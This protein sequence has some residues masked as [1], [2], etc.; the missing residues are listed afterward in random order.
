[1]T[2]EQS[3]VDITLCRIIGLTGGIGM[4]KT[5]VSQYVG[6]TYQLPILDADIY[7]REAVLPGSPILSTIVT[8]FG[9]TLLLA[10][11]T[12]D[13]RRLGEIVFNHP[14]QRQ[15]LEQQIHPYVQQAMTQARDRLIQQHHFTLMMVIPLLFEANLTHLVTETWVVYCSK[16]RQ[17]D[18]LRQRE[19]LT[20]DQIQGR[21]NSQMPI[22]AKIDRADIQLNNDSTQHSLLRQ[23]D[24][25]L[26]HSV[27][28]LTTP[29]CG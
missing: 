17:I 22:Q 7:A 8:R 14:P 10:D 29:T 9:S 3:P 1:M 16:Q 23:V 4:G 27:S 28:K 26:A 15:W 12:L 25:A 21:I 19:Q 18:R 2:A 6:H 20:S 5:T 11:G 24:Q 13:R